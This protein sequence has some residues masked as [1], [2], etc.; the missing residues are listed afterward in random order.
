LKALGLDKE[1]IQR[2]VSALANSI[3][4]KHP[5]KLLRKEL[6]MNALSYCSLK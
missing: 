4:P 2:H 5:I 3:R 1:K 6:K